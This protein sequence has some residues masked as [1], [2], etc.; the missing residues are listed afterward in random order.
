MYFLRGYLTFNT[1]KTAS[2][3]GGSST[4]CDVEC[5][6]QSRTIKNETVTV[7]DRSS[8]ITNEMATAFDT[9]RTIANETVTAKQQSSNGL[10]EKASDVFGCNVLDDDLVVQVEQS[11]EEVYIAGATSVD[12]SGIDSKLRVESNIQVF[13]DGDLICTRDLISDS[14]SLQSLYTLRVERPVPALPSMP[15]GLLTSI[16]NVCDVDMLVSLLC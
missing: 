11:S 15:M 3:I 9:G 8:T 16:I 7:L 10:I 14:L 4:R 5:I 1:T 6:A 2:E 12:R 13:D